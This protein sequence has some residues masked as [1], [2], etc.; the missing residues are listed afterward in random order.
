MTKSETMS[1]IEKANWIAANNKDKEERKSKNTTIWKASG[2]PHIVN[3]NEIHN[4][5]SKMKR[6]SNE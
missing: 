3:S 4:C 1:E 5:Y 2:G 6:G